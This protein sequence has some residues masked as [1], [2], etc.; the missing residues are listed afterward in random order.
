MPTDQ[1]QMLR[2]LQSFPHKIGSGRIADTAW[3]QA[4]GVAAAGAELTVFPGVVHKPL[5]PQIRV[6][7]TLA[8]GRWRIPYKALG[9]ARALGL[10]DQ[11]VARRLEQ[12]AGSV[13][14]V[15]AWPLGARRTLK[16]ARRL[17]ITSVLERPNAHTRFAYTV[18]QQECERIGVPLP[19][20]HEHA[21]NEHYLRLEEE[22]YELADFLLCPSEFTRQ[23]F[24][25]AGFPPG[26][27]LRHTYGYDETCFYPPPEPRTREAGLTMVYVGVAA[28]RK[29]L[30]FALEAWLR[31]RASKEG[32]F[33][34]AGEFLPAYREHLAA[35]LEHPSVH[36]LGHRD[37][38]PELMRW[39]DVFVL[40]TIEEGYGLACVEALASGCV[41]LVS[42]ACTE[43][44]EHEVNALVHP[45]GD[46]DTLTRHI[47]LLHDDRE[48]LDRLSATAIE[49]APR[50][51]WTRAGEVLLGTYEEA[52]AAGG[53]GSLHDLASPPTPDEIGRIPADLP[54]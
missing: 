24:L 1:P 52:V 44:C 48:Q 13:D 41:P 19:R 17:G 6:R 31:S 15:H 27:L 8:R 2:V 5:P 26:K 16:E 23:T 3:Y 12:L 40:P 32:T 22:E 10:H 29:G 7:P 20:N 9:R 11:I 37:D 43:V 42:K 4:Q 49:G 51:T 36:V 33:L 47:N 18:V 53:S 39:S 50:H 34:V 28:V 21:F 14:V 45:I 30:H 46:V 38:V 54:E 35:A 25:D